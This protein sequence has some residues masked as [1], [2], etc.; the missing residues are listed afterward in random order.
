MTFMSLTGECCQQKHTQHA[1]STKREC[2]YLNG[3]IEK[4][5]K[6][7]Y[8]KISPKLA[9]PRDI[10][11][12]RRRRRMVNPRDIAGERRRR[13]MVNPRDIAGERRRRRMVNPRDIAGERRRRRMVNPRDIA[14]E[15]RR[16]RMV[17]PR[18]IA[19]ERRRRCHGVRTGKYVNLT[20]AGTARHQCQSH[21]DVCVG[22]GVGWGV[23]V[24][25]TL[26]DR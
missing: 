16:R 6:V 14:G 18:D 22:G 26:N 19:G 15:R 4:K 24:L 9:N 13:R 11:G 2:D 23:W 12:E 20:C 8:T 17:N 3:G 10:A 7:T 1:P 25:A 5:K 21:F